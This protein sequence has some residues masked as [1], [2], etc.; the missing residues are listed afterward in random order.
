MD[1]K[2]LDAFGMDTS[3]AL[4]EVLAKT[5]TYLVPYSEL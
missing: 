3:K 2:S 5:N 4:L 1:R